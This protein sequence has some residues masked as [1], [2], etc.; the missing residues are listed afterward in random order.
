MK[1][2][3][4]VTIDKPTKELGL[5]N[6]NECIEKTYIYTQILYML[7]RAHVHINFFKCV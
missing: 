5:H 2:F 3:F 7:K 1:V 6:T 4:F